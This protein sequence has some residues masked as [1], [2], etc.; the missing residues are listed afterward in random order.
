MKDIFA[1]RDNLTPYQYPTAMEFYHEQTS[2]RWELADINFDKDSVQWPGLNEAIKDIIG[3]VLRGF[4]QTE[5]I[6][7]EYWSSNIPRW[8]PHPEICLMARRLGDMEGVHAL[9][10]NQ[11]S[12]ILNL[13]TYE[14]FKRDSSALAK[15]EFLSKA[16]AETPEEIAIDLAIFSGITE[17]VLLFSS[18]A[19]VQW[20]KLNSLLPGVTTVIEYSIRDECTTFDSEVLCPS[21]WVRVDEIDSKTPIAQYDPLTKEISFVVP[22]HWTIR[23]VD[24]NLIEF[25]GEKLPYKAKVTKGHRMLSRLDRVSEYK[26]TE[27]LDLKPHPKLM[28]PL[29]GYTLSISKSLTDYERFLIALQADGFLSERYTGTIC[30][31]R[32]VAFTFSKSRKIERFKDLLLKLGFKYTVNY[33]SAKDKKNPRQKFTVSVPITNILSKTFDWVD[34]S[35]ISSQWATEFLD[36]LVLWDGW[37]PKETSNKSNYTYYSSTIKANVD[38]VQAVAALCGKWVTTSVQRDNRSKTF[39][40]VYRCYI[41]DQSEKR[42]G[43]VTK[44]EVH[45]QGKVYCPT[46]PTGAFVMRYQDSVTITGNC[47]HSKAGCWLF[48]EV[49]KENPHLKTPELTDRI[50]QAALTAIELESKFIDTVFKDSKLPNLDPADLKEFVKSRANLI[51]E[52]LGLNDLSI[53]FDKNASDRIAVWFDLVNLVAPITDN[54]ALTPTSYT[55]GKFRPTVESFKF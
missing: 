34:L 27:A 42:M 36:E 35:Q 12:T 19:I 55:K 51:F 32:P 28:C 49:I 7:G 3:G 1:K 45:Y 24:E 33:E 37:V 11:L 23:E 29:A 52:R 8:F 40:D 53:E 22:S 18:F 5:H 10:Y 17:G 39:S 2:A 41:H 21:G 13:D 47:L 50:Y 48:T 54:F 15:L 38:I 4:V 46:V 16:R 25:G 43:S 26:F 6:V 31:T 20:L 44:T 14:A 30:G 9:S